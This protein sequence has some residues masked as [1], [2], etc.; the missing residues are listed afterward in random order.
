MYKDELL[1][2]LQALRHVPEIRELLEILNQA[3]I[4]PATMVPPNALIREF[5]GAEGE[6][7]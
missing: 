1:E 5:I 2:E 7:R 4:V 3:D 6:R